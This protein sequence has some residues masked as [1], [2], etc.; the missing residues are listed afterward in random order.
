M[1]VSMVGLSFGGT[2]IQGVSFNNAVPVHG[3]PAFG[4]NY[5]QNIGLGN[6]A[7]YRY[8]GSPVGFGVGTGLTTGYG[9]SH[10]GSAGGG[11]NI[12][13]GYLGWFAF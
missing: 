2:A 3:S 1:I 8:P 4:L 12:G 9:S 10:A 13:N 11:F 7:G 6:L 5:K